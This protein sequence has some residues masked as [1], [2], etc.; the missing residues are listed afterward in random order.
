MSN[1]SF[2][3]LSGDPTTWGV[4]PIGSTLVGIN[5][6]MQLTVVTNN[7]SGVAVI[8]PLVSSAPANLSFTNVSGTTT[9]NPSAGESTAIGTISASVGRTVPIVLD[10][11]GQTDGQL[12]D[13]TLLYPAMDSLI[14]NFYNTIGSG[15]PLYVVQSSTAGGVT[16]SW[17]RF[18]YS[19]ALGLW[20]VLANKTPAY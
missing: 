10:T 5:L 7:G 1:A 19:A 4:P 17:T 2:Q 6:S 3:L 12:L 15:S 9:L 8:S 18:Q 14:V 16:S 13:V 11:V 20:V